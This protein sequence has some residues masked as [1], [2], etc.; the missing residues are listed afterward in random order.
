MSLAAPPVMLSACS[1]SVEAKEIRMG[2]PKLLLAVGLACGLA[3]GIG[4]RTAE[5]KEWKTIRFGM[6]ASY[7]P[8][9]S[10]NQ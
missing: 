9:E 4:A 8:F 7:A 5:A 3:A 6:D 10:V 1:G 2:V